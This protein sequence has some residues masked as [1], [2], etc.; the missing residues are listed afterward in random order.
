MSK[1]VLHYIIILGGVLYIFFGG[2]LKVKAAGHTGSVAS[3]EY[4]LTGQTINEAVSNKVYEIADL[5]FTVPDNTITGKEYKIIQWHLHGLSFSDPSNKTSR[6]PIEDSG[7]K[8]DLS[9]TEIVD[10]TGQNW[11]SFFNMQSDGSFQL[12]T[13]PDNFYGH[14]Y[15]IK[16]Y[17]SIDHPK[18]YSKYIK[19]GYLSFPNVYFRMSYNQTGYNS[20]VGDE[21]I[22]TDQSIRF[23]IYTVNANYLDESGNKLLDTIQYGGYSGDQYQTTYKDIEGHHLIKIDGAETGQFTEEPINVNYIYRKNLYSID[24]KDST[25]FVGDTWKAED[26]FV[27]ATDIDGNV[28]DF[29]NS[30]I[31]VEGT[32]DTTTPGTYTIKYSNQIASKTIT[33]IVK[34]QELVLTVP[35]TMSFGT[36]KFGNENKLFWPS[37]SKVAV[38]SRSD[39]K[40]ALTVKLSQTA[41]SDFN[42]FIK[43]NGKNLS[44]EHSS[45]ITDSQGPETV[46]DVLTNDKFIYVDYSKVTQLR[47]D[48]GTLQ[49]TL[50]PSTKGVSE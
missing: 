6:I 24:A 18:D 17:G 34:K 42:Q 27:S 30:S 5:T 43:I 12:R 49:W 2:Q 4:S 41:N 36:I 44:T 13:F 38:Q 46:T 23:L 10:E 29:N 40:W 19:D 45:I 21:P 28:I 22:L 48:T 26:N 3:I 35:S 16:L 1:R 8:L 31:K 7:V 33:V 15:T 37:D 32:V 20:W 25:L 11:T 47:S 39:Q 9:K 14:T 50:T